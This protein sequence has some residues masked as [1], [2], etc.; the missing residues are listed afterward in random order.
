MKRT[1]YRLTVRAQSDVVD[2]IRAL[3]AWL[4]QLSA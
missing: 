4:K 2:E 3:R 1:T